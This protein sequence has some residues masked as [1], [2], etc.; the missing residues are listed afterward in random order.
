MS[1]SWRLEESDLV[2]SGRSRAGDKV[3]EV[4]LVVERK[5]EYMEGNLR[6]RGDEDEGDVVLPALLSG[7][8]LGVSRSVDGGVWQGLGRPGGEHQGERGGQEGG[9]AGRGEGHRET[10]G[11]LGLPP[12]SVLVVWVVNQ[13]LSSDALSF[14]NKRSF[15]Q[16]S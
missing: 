16:F 13:M 7:D 14:V 15:F 4:V 2:V 11:H 12:G 5:V 6:D 9:V 3:L 10:P 1:R 8:G